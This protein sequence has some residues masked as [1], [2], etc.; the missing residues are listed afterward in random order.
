MASYKP[1]VERILELISGTGKRVVVN[2]QIRAMSGV[3]K[4]F[5]TTGTAVVDHMP[6]ILAGPQLLVMLE[7]M[8]VS[9]VIN[10][11]FS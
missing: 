9:K 7:L 2:G 5:G 1:L 4:N 6:L 8:Y 3:G 10:H 11:W